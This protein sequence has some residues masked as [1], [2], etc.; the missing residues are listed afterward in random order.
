[1][2]KAGVVV[3]VP[4][5]SDEAVAAKTGKTWAEW[6]NL[7]DQ[8]DGTQLEHKNIAALLVKQHGLPGWWA[9]NV[10]VEYERSRGMRERHQVSDGYSVS[11]TKTL[12]TSVPRLYAATA[13]AAQRSKWFPRGAFELSSKTKDKY[14][15]GAWKKQSRLEFGFYAKGEGKAQIA[16][17]VTKL[18]DKADVE[19]ERAAWRAALTKLQ[20]MLKA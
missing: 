7:L 3:Y 6:F 2:S 20:G 16:L 9:Q 15:R 1:M 17:A 12:P 14:F 10:T 8:A 11:V 13:N 19:K 5:M 4:S 18:A